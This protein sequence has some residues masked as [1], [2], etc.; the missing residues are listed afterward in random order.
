MGG[1]INVGHAR[2]DMLWHPEPELRGTYGILSSCVLTIALC[3]WTA[4]HLNIQ[5]HNK[6]KAQIWR[7]IWWLVLGLFAPELI[8]WAAFEQHQEART[9]NRKLKDALG[10]PEPVRSS[11]LR[12]IQLWIFTRRRKSLPAIDQVAAA[13]EQSEQIPSTRRHAWTM[14]HSYYAIMGGFAFDSDVAK[15]D[16]LPNGRKRVTLTSLGVLRLA[17]LTPHLLPDFSISQI[18]DKSKASNIAK[19]IVYF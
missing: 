19:T 11:H 10:E 3:V 7:K 1:G 5:E 4:V 6:S 2:H 8:A 9:L 12:R 16:F 14:T 13:E 18:R 15:Q 17:I